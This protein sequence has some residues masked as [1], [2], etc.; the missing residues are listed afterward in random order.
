MGQLLSLYEALDYTG[1]NRKQLM[2]FVKNG[3]LSYINTG[4]GDQL[5]R[6][7]FSRKTLDQFIND[8]QSIF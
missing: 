1:L 5:P 3:S 6:Y 8:V 4:M 2:K 7:Y